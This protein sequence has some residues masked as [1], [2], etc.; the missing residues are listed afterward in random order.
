M[1]N[2]EIRYSPDIQDRKIKYNYICY[3]GHTIESTETCP[4]F[5]RTHSLITLNPLFSSIYMC[6]RRKQS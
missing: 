1:K 4:L 3:G 2:I 5:F 6:V